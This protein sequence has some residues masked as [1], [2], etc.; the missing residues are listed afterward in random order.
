MLLLLSSITIIII[1]VLIPVSSRQCRTQGADDLR[2][3]T[4]V[5]DGA[6]RR[7]ESLN[8]PPS[9]PTRDLRPRRPPKPAPDSALA[10]AAPAKRATRVSQPIPPSGSVD[11]TPN[12]R[13]RPA[14]AKDQVPA[15]PNVTTLP[16]RQ[17]RRSEIEHP[18][19]ASAAPRPT[20]RA[21]GGLAQMQ[22]HANT[23]PARAAKSAPLDEKV[24]AKCGRDRSTRCGDRDTSEQK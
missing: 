15:Q 11:A 9:P 7:R 10:H 6:R 12:Q 13:P 19:S 21:F 23:S 17:A 4:P 1:T 18:A 20:L 5:K 8:P 24:E 14:R 2:R 16:S 22:K 3:G